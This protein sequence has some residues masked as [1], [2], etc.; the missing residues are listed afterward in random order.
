M[1]V[2][3]LG[4]FPRSPDRIDGG[5]A[6]AVTYLA[7]ALVREPGVELI[8]VRVSGGARKSVPDSSLGWPVVDLPLDP[9]S[10]STLFWRQKRR[11]RELISEYRPD[12]VHAQGADL[13]GLLAV[14]C[15]VPAVITIHGV[16]RECAKLQTDPVVKARDMLQS[17]LTERPTVRNARDVI[18]ISP[19][20]ARYYRNEIK[21]RVHDIPNAV[22]PG[23]FSVCRMPER[24]R[25][26]FAGR[27]SKGKG[28][29]EL[30]RAVALAP[31]CVQKLVLAG[32]T[33]D[34]AYED[35]VR[36]EVRKLGLESRVEFAGL[37]DEPSLL[38]EFARA[39]ALVLPSYQE[40]A[41]M[42]V[43][44]AMAAGLPVLATR[45]GGIPFQVEDGVSGLLFDA[46][47][48]HGLA[49]LL[50]RIK[51]DPALG[52]RLGREARKAAVAHYD[53]RVVADM[54]SAAYKRILRH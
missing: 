20:I 12:I 16:L 26:L 33:P 32:G 42:V 35:E 52:E 34:K 43:Q 40:T 8:G 48:V 18:S 38:A 22:G 28:I 41:P 37:L 15:K 19:Y 3:M 1:R 9:G 44:Q 21:G 29:L 25:F 14:G 30:V 51:G 23:F 27:I 54:T 53:A 45:V 17:F 5:V 11:F 6:A 10:V 24:G 13:S 47:D 7:Q 49:G 36:R 50:E 46:V 4:P 31:A 2:M 39:E